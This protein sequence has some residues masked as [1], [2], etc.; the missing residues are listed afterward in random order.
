MELARQTIS[1]DKTVRSNTIQNLKEFNS[2]T[3]TIQAKN[4]EQLVPFVPAI[5]KVS[6]L[7]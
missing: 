2:K 1:K 7:I 5:E 3:L 4:G 6:D